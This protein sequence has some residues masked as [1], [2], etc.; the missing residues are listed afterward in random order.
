MP[1][2]NLVGLYGLAVHAVIVITFVVRRS[3]QGEQFGPDLLYVGMPLLLAC[4][5]LV[6]YMV[7]PWYL[8]R[9][10]GMQNA[11]IIDSLVGMLIEYIIFTATAILLGVY[12]GFRTAADGALLDGLAAGVVRNILW[13][14]ATFMVQIL[15]LGNLCGLLGWLVLKKTK[16]A[17]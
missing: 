15:V 16:A 11:V 1:K 13:V 4:S 3:L 2:K 7:G 9:R 10:S 12:D 17:Q 14:Y 8:K 6:Y 5:F